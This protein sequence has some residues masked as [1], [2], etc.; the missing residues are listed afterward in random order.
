MPLLLLL[1]TLLFSQPSLAQTSALD[2][3]AERGYL[4][5]GTTFDYR[6][7]TYKEGRQAAGY[8]VDVAR[9]MAREL[10]VDLVFVN[11][12][13]TDLLPHLQEHKFDLAVGGIT[14]T[15]KRQTKAGFT[16][17]VFSI[18]KCALVRRE[19]A[20]RLRDLTAIDGPN[21]TVAVNPGGTNEA[22]VREHIQQAQ[23]LVVEDNLAIPE[24]VAQGQADAMITDNLEALRAAQRDPRLVAIS[25]D[26]P[27]TAE[28]LGFVTQRHDQAFLN[29]LNLFLYQAEAD[30]R[31]ELLRQK[32]GL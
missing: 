18:G 29:W 26:S 12:T 8:D 11:T 4:R 27:W 16:D 9:L 1:L 3:V 17:P 15:L 21:L 31:L 23:I 2:T 24:L 13:W 6:P 28:T 19:D 30:G 32:H 20:E 14:R 5:V 7:F 22:Y 25:A 10:G